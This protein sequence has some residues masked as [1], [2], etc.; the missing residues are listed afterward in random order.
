MNQDY[1]IITDSSCDLPQSLADEYGLIVLP[2]T[3]TVEGKSYRNLLDGSEISFESLYAKLRA[4]VVA[5]T[6]AVNP[7]AFVSVMEPVLQAGRDILYIGFS[8]GLSGTYQSGCIAAAEL[9]EKYPERKIV[10]VDS[11]CA[12]LGQGLLIHHAVLHQRA[13]ESI[14]QVQK[15][16]E[17]NKLHLCH[18]FT[19]D[20]LMFLKRGG[21]I[22]ATTA[23]LGT[24]LKIKPVM[25]MDNDGKLASVSKVRGRRASLDALAQKLADTAIEPH[26]QTVFISHG[27]CLDDAQYLADVIQKN[28]GVKDITINFVGPVI[29]AHS[30]PGTVSVFFLGTER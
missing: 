30:G 18:W 6:N 2:L 5:T 24:L 25:H 15:W 21:R 23:L 10:T 12:S 14:E 22:P 1:Q 16:C 28:T 27:D 19:V 4:G 20:D 29:G 17:D 8:T 3:V 26:G 9:Q 13:G 11:L 7:D